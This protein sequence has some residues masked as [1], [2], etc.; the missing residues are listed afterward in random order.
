MTT[1]VSIKDPPTRRAMDSRKAAVDKRRRDKP[2]PEV[3]IPVLKRRFSGYLSTVVQVLPRQQEL[4]SIALIGKALEKVEFPRLTWRQL[5]QTRKKTEPGA[6]PVIFHAR[7]N[8]DMIFGLLLKH[9]LRCRLHLVFTSVAQRDHTAFT[10][11]LYR[12]MDTILCPSERSAS[13]LR[14]KTD[15]IVP[16]GIDTQRYHPAPDRDQA[17]RE[18]GLP[19]QRG[20]GIFGRV[21]ADKGIPE[22][23]EAMCRLLPQHPEYTAVVVGRVKAGQTGLVRRLKAKVAR[24]GLSDRVVWLGERPFAEIPGWFRCMS[25]VVA[26]SRTEGFGLTALEAMAS[27]VPVVATQTGGFEM[28]IRPDMDGKIVPCADS[29]ALTRAVGEL[30]ADPQRLDIMGQAA[31][32]RVTETFSIDQEARNL[33]A[34][35]RRIQRSYR[36]SHP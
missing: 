27:G 7:R 25:L 13:Y 18:G 12:K 2:E 5:L 29:D 33:V 9:L 3:V 6:P 19:G 31:R 1:D 22:F 10:R 11:L 17:W 20:I 30:I 36:N 14:V 21:R 4:I 35:Y 32:Q 24:H 26:A 23:I 16:H 8:D 15:G 34:H 28:V